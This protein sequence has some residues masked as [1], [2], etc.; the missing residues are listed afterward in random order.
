MDLYESICLPEAKI[1]LSDLKYSNM[2]DLKNMKRMEK[3]KIISLIML[4]ML[5]A[6]LV[7]YNWSDKLAYQSDN[8]VIYIS[9][10]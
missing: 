2:T 7:Y 10:F 3:L 6:V 1:I 9:V 4:F 5:W 8:V